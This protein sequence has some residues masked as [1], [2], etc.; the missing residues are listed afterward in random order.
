MGADRFERCKN[1]A[2]DLDLQRRMLV[3]KWLYING[4]LNDTFPNEQSYVP[5]HRL[6]NDEVTPLYRQ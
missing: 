2:A 1:G 5:G 4:F 6:E 3:V